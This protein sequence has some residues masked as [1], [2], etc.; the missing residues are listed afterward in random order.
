VPKQL[1]KIVLTV[2]ALLGCSRE[3]PSKD[4][5][6]EVRGMTIQAEESEGFTSFTRKATV[7]AT[8][9]DAK[10]IY[11]VLYRV[12][13]ISG[14][15]PAKPIDANRY[16]GVLVVDGVGEYADYLGARDKKTSYHE[17]ETWQPEQVELVQLGYNVWTRAPAKST[18]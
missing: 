3:P 17:A 5:Q 10:L 15:D 4:V 13:H 16:S 9:A 1:R 7:V 2:A 12:K 11:N 6:F 18:H 8:G 14:G